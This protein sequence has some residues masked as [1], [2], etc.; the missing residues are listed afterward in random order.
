LNSV[1]GKAHLSWQRRARRGL[2]RRLRRRQAGVETLEFLATLLYFI[3]LMFVVIG[4][5]VWMFNKSVIEHAARVGARQG[6][7]YWEDPNLYDADG[8]DAPQRPHIRVNESMITSGVDYYLNNILRASAKPE[9]AVTGWDE[10]DPDNGV[11]P[12]EVDAESGVWD[13][14]TLSLYS[15]EVDLTYDEDDE[16]EA[17]ALYPVIV[18]VFG[19]KTE[20]Q[21]GNLLGILSSDA[22]TQARL[23]ADL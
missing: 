6:S 3:A 22:N 20:E 4:A 18:R 19:S 5:S 21:L 11:A 7:L 23:E 14:Q 15:I 9:T 2:G 10:G 8:E 16:S 13:V 17:I 1:R 12:A